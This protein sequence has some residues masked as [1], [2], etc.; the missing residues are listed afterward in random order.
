MFSG[1]ERTCR[2]VKHI[3]TGIY[4]CRYITHVHRH[5]T[6]VYRHVTHLQTYVHRPVTH[7]HR[8][9][10]HVLSYETWSQ[11]GNTCAQAYITCVQACNTCAQAWRYVHRHRIHVRRHKYHSV[12]WGIV[13][14]SQILQK[15]QQKFMKNSQFMSK[16][17]FKIIPPP[18]PWI[19]YNIVGSRVLGLRAKS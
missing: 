19:N 3:G 11:A 12:E 1:M 14:H 4:M 15:F 17:N 6:H 8:Y 16:H 13:I 2:G 5:V 9:G 7:L 18:Y 10:L